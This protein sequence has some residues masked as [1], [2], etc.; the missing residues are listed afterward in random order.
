M[1]KLTHVYDIHRDGWKDWFQLHVSKTKEIMQRH[2]KA[3]N[4]KYRWNIF[5]IDAK[6][7]NLVLG[8]VQPVYHSEG[9]FA[10]MFLNEQALGGG[11][12]AHECLHVA[13]AHE[14][15]V[16]QFKMDYGPECGEDE[17]RLAYYLTEVVKSVNNVIYDNGHAEPGRAKK[18][19]RSKL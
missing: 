5:D 17:E 11:V 1:S 19:R 4:K 3:M 16:L 12:V 14:R 9:C 8:C 6:E 13:M 10:I 18:G 15:H 2:V 7:F